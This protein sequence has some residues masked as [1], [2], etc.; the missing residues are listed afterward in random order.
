MKQNISMIIKQ[1]HFH[2]RNILKITPI[3][4]STILL[5]NAACFGSY[6]AA[7]SHQR[8]IWDISKLYSILS[9]ITQDFKG[10]INLP[11][12]S[13]NIYQCAKKY[14][15]WMDDVYTLDFGMWVVCTCVQIL[16]LG[17]KDAG[18]KMVIEYEDVR[19]FSKNNQQKFSGMQQ[20][21]KYKYYTCTNYNSIVIT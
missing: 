21:N 8:A 11:S 1:I 4:A 16:Y 20:L 5:H 7:G 12:M 13:G 18:M 2:N 17:W 9:C 3:R 15:H 6:I 14:L 19:N 10:S